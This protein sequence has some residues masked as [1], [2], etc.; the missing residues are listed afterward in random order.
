MAIAF[1]TP[2]VEDDL[3]SIHTRAQRELEIIGGSNLLLTGAGGFLAYYFILSILYWND[4]Y[5]NRTIK[6]T[7][8]SRFG[9]GIPLWLKKLDRRGDLRII[10]SDIISDSLPEQTFEYIVHAASL[11]SPMQY[12]QFP[13]E[14]MSANV[15]GLNRLLKDIISKQKKIKKLLY[16]SSS[17][18][19][20]DPT[21]GNIPTPESY[22]GNVSCTGPR[23]CYDESK[24]FCE[25]LCVNYVRVHKLPIVIARPFNNYGPGMKIDDGRVIA[26]FAR[27]IIQ[28]K[29]IVMYSDGKP[30]RTYCYVSDAIAGYFKLLSLG[31]SGESYNIGV[32]KPEITVSELA[33]NMVKIAKKNFDYSG[34]IIKKVSKDID[35]LSDNPQRR[36]PDITK[37]GKELGY[38]PV[39]SLEDGLNRT[40]KWYEATTQ[41]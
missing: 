24:R 20:G 16:F 1:P 39:I 13:I 32:S 36:C 23:A 9:S 28:K 34:N 18:I 2:I 27:S 38:K 29:N 8:L 41:L 26:D 19:Y 25:T 33:A 35:Y 37:A 4:R 22:R 6:I 10:A 3:R 31:K 15:F 30:S 21:K 7:A 5:P 12:R 11:A 40:L 14:T 17:E